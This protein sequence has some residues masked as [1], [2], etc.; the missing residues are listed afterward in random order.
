MFQHR[1]FLEKIISRALLLILVACIAVLAG[2]KS[3]PIEQVRIS[4][5]D[6]FFRRLC[7]EY[8]LQWQFDHITQVIRVSN[9]NVKADLLMESSVV[10]FDDEEVLLSRPI[11]AFNSTVLVP[12]DF[13]SKVIERLLAESESLHDYSVQTIRKVVIDAG[14]GGKDPGAIGTDGTYEKNVVLDIAHRLKQILE[15]QDIEVLMTRN[16]D[17]FISLK[18]RTEIASQSNADLFISIHANSSPERWVKG[19]EVFTLRELKPLEFEEG[20]RIENHKL[21]F[22]RL[23]MKKNDEAL[24]AILSDLLFTHKQKYS[25]ILANTISDKA[26]RIVRTK[27]R[28]IK[29]SG[30][31][32]L[33]NT[34]MPAV[35][36]EVGFLTNAQEEKSLNSTA[37]RQ[38][39][40]YGIARSIVDNAEFN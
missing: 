13:K 7:D 34:L 22:N 11:R 17:V 29:K 10:M 20:Q 31:Y 23:S 2:C 25:S 24:E 21:M 8:N 16:T 32:V 26:S 33:R 19:V 9:G 6:D 39:M 4:E 28:G 14:H 30:F 5:Q 36:V 38:K 3:I 18:K 12:L 27:N 37:Y 15:N 1:N 40:A 35:L